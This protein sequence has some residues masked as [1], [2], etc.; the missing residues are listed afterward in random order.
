MIEIPSI[1]HLIGAHSACK[2]T[3]VVSGCS[4]VL[5]A[6]HSVYEQP[7]YQEVCEPPESVHKTSVYMHILILLGEMAHHTGYIYISW[8]DI[9][10]IKIS[11]LTLGISGPR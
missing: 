3:T 8:N 6:L 11:W 10:P 7:N 5:K 9:R 2:W 4:W 1:M